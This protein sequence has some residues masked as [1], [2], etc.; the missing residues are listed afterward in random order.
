MNKVGLFGILETK[1]KSRNWNKVTNNICSNWA[2]CTNSYLHS[3]GRIWIIWDPVLF[4]VDILDVTIQCIHT[5][6]FDKARRKDFYFTVVYGLNSLGDREPLWQSIRSYHLQLNSPWLLCGDFNAIM[7]RNERIGGAEITNAELRPMADAIR[8]YRIDRVFINEEWLEQYPDSFAHFLLEGL[9]DHCPG[10]VHLEEERQR[11]GNSFKYYNMWSMAKEYKEVVIYGWSREVQGT[12]M[13]RIVSK[14]K[15]L[16]KGLLNLNKDNFEDIENLTN[17]TELSLKHFQSL[18][19]SDPYNKEWIEN[20]RASAQELTDMVK[21]RDQFLKQKAKCDWMKYGDENTA[22]F[23]AAIKKRRARNRVFQVKDMR[24]SLCSDSKGA[25]LT[26]EHCAILNAEITGEEVRDAMFAI[27]G[28]KAPG[29]DGY[30]SQFFKD[31]WP[32]VGGDVII[33][34]NNAYETGKLLKQVNNTIITLI[35]KMEMPETVLHF[36]PIACCNIIYKCLSKVICARMSR[37]LP[38]IISPS[39]GAFIKGRDI[40]GNILICQDLIRLYNRKSCSPRVLLK[41]DLQKAYDSIEWSFVSEMLEATGIPKKFIE[42]LMNCVTSPSYSLSLNGEIFGLFKGQRGLRQ[43]DPLS[44]L[45][46]TLCLEYL[47]RVL[48]IVQKHKNFR[49]HPL[50]KRINLTHLC[51]ADDLIM[52]CKGERGSIELLLQAF[53]YFSKASGLVMNSV[54][55]K[56]AH[57]MDYEPHSGASWAW[58]KICQVKNKLKPLILTGEPY[59]IQKGYDFMKPLTVKVA[60]CCYSHKIVY[61]VVDHMEDSFATK[62]K[63]IGV[64]LASLMYHLWQHRNTC[65][66]DQVVLKPMVLVQRLKQDVRAQLQLIELQCKNR[67]VIEWVKEL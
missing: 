61:T 6:V 11:R 4:E 2:I 25:C 42:L 49:H 38:D 16:K 28:N 19:V 55:I 13:F 23:H 27:P 8:D 44:P 58:R 54:Y 50:C 67:T 12:P 32:I 21:A 26:P 1:I 57:W 30:S 20:E 56:S 62:K 7:E 37:I 53:K 64:I 65:R 59:T 63:V 48:M 36:R 66:I 18:L 35:P 51:F 15:G 45:L 22:F 31:N 34:V 60:W 41:L 46:F 14:L 39:Q 24:G 10:L 47:S 33:A 3:G 9:F 5:K 52:F 43:G 40:V 29:P 17:L